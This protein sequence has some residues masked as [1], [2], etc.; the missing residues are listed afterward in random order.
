MYTQTHVQYKQQYTRAT[1]DQSE[2]VT[3]VDSTKPILCIEYNYLL[4]W[5]LFIKKPFY[6]FIFH[7][8]PNLSG[9]K[10]GL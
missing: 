1:S 4:S 9:I 2:P 7:V 10:I 5:L 8:F 3:R 6:L